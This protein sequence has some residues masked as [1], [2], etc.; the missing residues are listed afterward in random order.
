MK[1]FIV[2]LAALAASTAIAQ[3]APGDPVATPVPFGQVNPA[4][5]TVT[6]PAVDISCD[7]ACVLRIVTAQSV[8]YLC[9][10]I[11]T[12]SARLAGPVPLQT[13]TSPKAVKCVVNTDAPQNPGTPAPALAR[14]KV[15][16]DQVTG[17]VR[18]TVV[19]PLARAELLIDQSTWPNYYYGTKNAVNGVVTFQLVD[20]IRDGREHL[21]DVRLYSAAGA[22]ASGVQ[23]PDV[24]P[25]R[26]VIQPPA[27]VEQ[28]K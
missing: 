24:Y 17:I 5:I 3:F 6:P 16:Y 11:F 28:P 4:P 1:R 12:L 20:A 7:D 21:F 27:P 13:A 25:V 15:E 19:P 9:K 23:R 2:L 18:V 22:P 14:G 10:Q 8:D 26:M